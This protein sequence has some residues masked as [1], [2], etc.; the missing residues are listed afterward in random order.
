MKTPLRWTTFV[1]TIALHGK[2]FR[3]AAVSTEYELLMQISKLL[4][5]ENAE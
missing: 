4:A 5:L 2:S 1:H 3:W